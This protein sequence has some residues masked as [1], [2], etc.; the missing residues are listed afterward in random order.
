[1]AE[2]EF[3]RILLAVDRSPQSRHAVGVVADLAP[4]G[5]EV[6]VLHVWN[7]E[8]KAIEGRWDVE[9]RSEAQELVSDYAAD[10]ADAGLE[11]TTGV[12]NGTG[13]QI[14]REIARVAD[15][16]GAGLIAMGSRGRSDL[17]GILLGSVSHQVVSRTHRPVLI[18]RAAPQRS[19]ARRRIVLALAGGEE[20][21]SAVN[22]A[23]AVARRWRAEVVVFHVASMIAEPVAWI[24][25][26][27]Q[28]RAVV[29]AALAKLKA[30]GVEARAEIVIGTRIAGEIARAAEG[31]DADLVVMGS[32]RIGEL[33]SMLTSAVDHAV[34]NRVDRP[35][36]IAGRTREV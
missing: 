19:R 21:P 36:L 14:A 9:S 5:A 10:L 18:V 6:H 20:A 28:S 31:W 22:T 29:N 2:L 4:R 32:R 8:V 7:L 16:F 25:P 3:G 26:D 15:E 17:G 1:M 30:A 12:G 27:D 34:V 35:V 13:V 23:I 24:E 11:V 33:R